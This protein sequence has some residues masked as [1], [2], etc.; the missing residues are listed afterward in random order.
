MKARCV[1]ASSFRSIKRLPFGL[2]KERT[3]DKRQE[4][5]EQNGASHWRLQRYDQSQYSKLVDGDKNNDNS[6]GHQ[7]D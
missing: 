7:Q 3:S 4:N 6:N 2:V 1:N 5:N